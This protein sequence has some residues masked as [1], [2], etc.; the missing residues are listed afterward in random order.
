MKIVHEMR[1][2]RA[3]EPPKSTSPLPVILGAVIAFGIGLLGVSGIIKM[4]ADGGRGTTNIAFHD[5]YL[6]VTEASRNEVWRVKT[7]IPP[8]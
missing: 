7:K 2:R 4:P 5:G 3:F 1:E 6:Y 8:L